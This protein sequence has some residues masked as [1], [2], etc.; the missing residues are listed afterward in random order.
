MYFNFTFLQR[1]QI[2]EGENI[3][4]Y[5]TEQ[6]QQ[7]LKLKENIRNI[8]FQSKFQDE[9]DII[10]QIGQGNY[11]KVYLA[12]NKQNFQ[13]FAVKCFDKQK[14]KQSENGI[15]S[16]MNELKIMQN[17][18]D[19]PNIVKLHEVFEGDYTYY[20]V[21]ELIEGPSLQEDLYN[22]ENLYTNHQIIQIMKMLIL[23]IQYCSKKN[24][25]HRDLKPDNILLI[26]RSKTFSLK[27]VDFGLAAYSNQI[28]YIFPKCG[29]PGFV[30]PEIAN[31]NDKKKGYGV[32]CDVFSL[33]AIFFILL[34]GENLFQVY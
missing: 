25:M 23:A 14:L 19:H 7:C 13:K 20:L 27:I 26:K 17:V 24:I 5:I 10:Q 31:L 3:L 30:A 34:T 6:P 8:I 16:F 11:A 18:N 32:I 22:R 21:M 29:T 28:P 2:K 4:S 12:T 1:F 33:G 9:Y 15:N